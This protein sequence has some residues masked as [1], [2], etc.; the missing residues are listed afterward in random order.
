VL[1]P[2]HR[3]EAAAHWAIPP[4]HL[5]T[6]PGYAAVE[7][8]EA[9]AEGKVKAVWIMCTN[10]AVSTPALDLVEKALRQAELVVVQDAYHPTDTTR[11]ADVLLPAAQWPEKEGVMTNSERT[12]PTSP[13]WLRRQGTRSPAGRS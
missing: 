11:F 8:F 2:Q 9:L 10:P 1:D 4:E 7:L 12:L 3:V 13:A 5:S 6:E